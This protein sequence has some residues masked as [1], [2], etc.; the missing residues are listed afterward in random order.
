MFLW[1]SH[2]ATVYVHVQKARELVWLVL[3]LGHPQGVEA[4]PHLF[5]ANSPLKTAYTPSPYH[6]DH[7][8]PV[9]FFSHVP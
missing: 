4:L 3:S 8:E 6:R 2:Q 1:G 5:R 9:S 7:G